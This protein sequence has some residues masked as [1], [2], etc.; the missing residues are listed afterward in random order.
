[1]AINSHLPFSVLGSENPNPQSYEEE[2]IYDP[3][4]PKRKLKVPPPLP[5][6]SEL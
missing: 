3:A 5:P 4:G 2:Y 1:M 6:R